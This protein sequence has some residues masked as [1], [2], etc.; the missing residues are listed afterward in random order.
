MNRNYARTRYCRRKSMR[1]LARAIGLPSW[2]REQRAAQSPRR[3]RPQ[4]VEAQVQPGCKLHA[5]RV[6][7]QVLG[8]KA[9][10]GGAIGWRAAR[11]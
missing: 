5:Q 6:G 4:H 3:V 9:G 1:P 2:R 7:R 11:G 10:H 8:Q